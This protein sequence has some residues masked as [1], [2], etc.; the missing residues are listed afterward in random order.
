MNLGAVRFL[1]L[2]PAV[3]ATGPTAKNL[4][5]RISTVLDMSGTSEEGKL[6][7]E[8]KKYQFDSIVQ[9]GEASSVEQCAAVAKCIS[10]TYG[11]LSGRPAL[12]VKFIMRYLSRV[13]EFKKGCGQLGKKPVLQWL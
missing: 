11:R 8:E 13:T 1:G 7:E 4:F 10:A 3:L 9:D 6:S 5:R 2:D 12:I